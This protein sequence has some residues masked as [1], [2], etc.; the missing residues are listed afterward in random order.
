MGCSSAGEVSTPSEVEVGRVD[1]GTYR[2]TYSGKVDNL[3]CEFL[4]D[5]GADV[6]ILSS[7]FVQPGST[8]VSV[9]G[10]HLRYPTGEFVPAKCKVEVEVSLGRHSLR[11]PIYV[12]DISS[13]CILDTDFLS[14]TEEIIAGSCE[15]VQHQIKLKDGAQPI[16]QHTRKIPMHVEDEVDKLLE[17]MKEKGVIE[18]SQ[19]PWVS[20]VLL[21][22]KKDNSIRFCV[23]YRKLNDLT[24]KDSFP[25]P[26]IDDLLDR[27]A[28]YS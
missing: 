2:L 26:K 3:I 13:D 11:L 28:G 22:R 7:R 18:E 6:S 10:V 1:G 24:V 20:P 9:S 15:G 14:A 25:L 27:L 12:A 4:L 21:V 19:S 23:D 8:R 17:D 16:K 5:T